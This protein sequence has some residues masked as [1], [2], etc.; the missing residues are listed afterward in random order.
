MRWWRATL[1]PNW[2]HGH[3]H[4]P[5]F[6][7]GWY[8]KLI[9]E[10]TRHKLVIIPGVFLSKDPHAFIQVLDGTTSQT[11]YH[12]FPLDQ[13]RAA[14]E[15]FEIQ[16]GKSRFT[17]NQI[18]LDLERPEQS[19]HGSLRFFGEK[20]WPVNI[21]SPGIMGWYAWVPTMECYHGVVSLDHAL[22]GAL[23]VDGQ[24]IDFTNGRGYIEKDWGQS[25]PSAWIWMQSNHFEYPGT[26]LTASIAMIPW[27]K[28]RF[29]GF[30]VGLWF[31]GKLY[32]F[33]TYTGARTVSLHVDDRRVDWL[34]R[35]YTDR[36]MHT[37]HIVAT[38]GEAGLLAGPTTLDMGTRVA[39][40]LTAKIAVRLN[41]IVSGHEQV[42]FIG[43]GSFAGL[44]V[45]NVM[46]ELV[47]EEGEDRLVQWQM[48]R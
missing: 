41:R 6:F 12:R 37:L 33:A 24:S 29:K 40:T 1:N 19:L 4:K 2:F 31:Q 3:D 45:H 46:E 44:E 34:I 5:P 26:S 30:I 35:G 27:K 15:R 22:D 47:G 9:D 32:R 48:F 23:T 42:S 13:F 39:E 10:S 43:N 20:P 8:Y 21:L 11:W 38:R 18:S 14:H 16:V 25:F 36:A 7:E 17:A 28:T